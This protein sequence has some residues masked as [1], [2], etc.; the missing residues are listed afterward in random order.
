M[1]PSREKQ[2]DGGRSCQEEAESVWKMIKKKDGRS[3]TT[4]LAV[5][6]HGYEDSLKALV[7]RKD[8]SKYIVCWYIPFRFPSARWY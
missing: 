2:L 7:K 4:I 5:T 3:D 6:Q 1:P 8:I